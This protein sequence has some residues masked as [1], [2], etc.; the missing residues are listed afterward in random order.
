LVRRLLAAQ[1]P[2][3][4]SLKLQPVESAGWDNAIVRLRDDLMVRLPCRR[5]IAAHVS[6]EHRS[7]PALAPQLPLPTPVPLGRGAPGEGYP[8]HWTVGRWLTGEMAAV[9]PAAD[10]HKAATRLARF[11]WRLCKRS[12]RPAAWCTSSAV[13]L[14]PLTLGTPKTRLLS[15][16]TISISVQR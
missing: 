11:V 14:S 2:Q 3:W 15:W 13:F 5:V 7:L 4:V 8:W 6:N 12:T 9:A 10:M 16:L 1:F